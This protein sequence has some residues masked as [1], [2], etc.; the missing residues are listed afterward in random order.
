MSLAVQNIL[1]DW[2]LPPWLTGLTL[3]TAGI[4]LRGWSV[5]RKT[6]KAQFTA[7]RLASFF[8][9]LAVLWTAV[10]PPLDGLADAMLSAHMVEHLLLMSV[11]PPLLLYG[12][13]AVPLLRG[14]PSAWMLF[15]LAPLIRSV[16][17]RRFGHWLLSPPV[18][19]VAMNTA[20]LGWHIPA[21]YDFALEH[22]NWHVVE[23]I[24]FLAT[25]I[26]FWWCVIRPWPAARQRT[27]WGIIIFLL[28]ADIVNTILSAFLAFCGHPVYTYYLHRPN[29]FGISPIEDQILGAVIMWVF[30]SL[31][32]LIPAVYITFQELSPQHES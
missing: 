5:L 29:P 24:C 9:G 20:F 10:G 32:F 31:I 16:H 7:L 28:S 22:E 14:L 2:N 15:L 3:L 6:R 11:V 26:L 4:Y 12:L 13:P 18:A 8:S 19:W 27:R 23:H 25:S 21:A 17:L 30:G 1:V